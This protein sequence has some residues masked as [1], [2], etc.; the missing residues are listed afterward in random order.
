MKMDDFIA[1]DRPDNRALNRDK[2]A[3]SGDFLSV[4][5]EKVVIHNDFG[6]INIS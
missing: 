3:K 4:F 2:I 1:I 5:F 6:T